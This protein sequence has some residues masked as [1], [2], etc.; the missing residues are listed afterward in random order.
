MMTMARWQIW[1]IL[2]ICAF[3]V[4]FAAPNLLPR[5]QAERLPHW[6]PHQQ[7]SLG[8]D[9]QGGV[10]LLLEV[11]TKVVQ[12]DR[13]DRLARRRPYAHA[14]PSVSLSAAWRPAA[15]TRSRS[16][17]AMRASLSRRA[18]SCATSTRRRRSQP[19][20]TARSR[21]ARTTRKSSKRVVRPSRSRSR[22]CVVAST[23]PA[24]RKPQFR[25]RGKTAF[26]SRFLA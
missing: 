12:R 10:S 5:E 23:R 24:R 9:L 1:M 4:I 21:P 13:L 26:W 14:R 25:F 22:L 17:C 15:R 7:I 11:D 16:V 6:L 2:A 3:G 20:P 18:P 8:L 19:R